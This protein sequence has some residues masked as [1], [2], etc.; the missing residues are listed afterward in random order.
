MVV[1]LIV[2]L[3]SLWTWNGDGLA[4]KAAH[5]SRLSLL[6]GGESFTSSKLLE[7]SGT[8]LDCSFEN[9]TVVI[10]K[11]RN[12]DNKTDISAIKLSFCEF[13]PA[14]MEKVG[15]I[16]H[17]FD[18]LEELSLTDATFRDTSCE[19]ESDNRKEKILLPLAHSLKRIPRLKHLCLAG[20]KLNDAQIESFGYLFRPSRKLSPKMASNHSG[21]YLETL[22]LSRNSLTASSMKVITKRWSGALRSLHGLDLSYNALD[23]KGVHILAAGMEEFPLR[24]PALKMVHLRQVGA[25]I[26]SITHLL[27]ALNENII[28]GGDHGNQHERHAIANGVEVLDLSGNFLL[29][30]REEKLVK[31][32]S[33]SQG[34]VLMETS[35]S[36]LKQGHQQ[37]CSV[38][39]HVQVA[40]TAY[41]ELEFHLSTASRKSS[42]R[43]N[44][45]RL[46]RGKMTSRYDKV[47]KSGRRGSMGQRA[48]I[49]RQKQIRR[50]GCKRNSGKSPQFFSPEMRFVGSLSQF[51]RKA[52]KLNSL[53]LMKTHLNDRF[54]DTIVSQQPYAEEVDV[55]AEDNPL[56]QVVLI[57]MNPLS[58]SKK[59]KLLVCIRRYRDKNSASESASA[60]H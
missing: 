9:G 13:T 42:F 31:R 52:T 60:T 23:D 54:V 4:H 19:G 30:S 21:P 53:S 27:D 57:D 49:L 51:L 11:L 6:F 17:Q 58:P 45:K 10:D 32:R 38:I 3:L 14:E 50:P 15:K 43:P 37:V 7:E 34:E 55:Q 5:S 12:V 59:S 41:G 25:H 22:D 48:R 36:L 40:A 1:W 47:S 39:D 29:T 56:P 24:Y 20:C 28:D 16:I 2:S 18:H 44:L 8:I 46:G 35:K 33:K 26:G